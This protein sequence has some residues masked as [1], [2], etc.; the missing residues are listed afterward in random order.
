M[1]VS[2]S[3]GPANLALLTAA[4]VT[5]IF[6]ASASA[7]QTQLLQNRIPVTEFDARA[8]VS[9]TQS[10]VH[11]MPANLPGARQMV[12]MLNEQNA[13][14]ALSPRGSSNATIPSPTP[15][16]FYGGDLVFHGGPKLTSVKSH[17]I[18]VDCTPV[19]TCWGNPE[20]FLSDLGK[21][22]FIHLVDQ[23]TGSTANG[24][25]TVG[26]HANVS[27]GFFG[28]ALYPHD[29]FS[30]VHAVAKVTGT[31]YGHIYHI[32]LP[33]GVDTCFDLS[34]VCYSPDNPSSFFFCAYHGSVTFS[35]IGHVVYT[36]E[37]F[38]NVG[39]CRV[40]TPAPN[41]QLADSTNS[42]LSH[43][44]FEAI[45]DPDLNAWFN[46]T[47]LDLAGFEIGDECQPLGN[48]TGALDPTF[49]IN[50]KKYEV[51]TEY[52]NHYHAC[53]VVP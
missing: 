49:L 48:S 34:N 42:V 43:E 37:P 39:G 22:S 12:Q 23:Y 53:A 29:L 46:Q 7:Q 2:L 47:S 52:S 18:Y 10:R 6:C 38:Q 19:S 14:Q 31:G 51:Q 27:Y 20:G 9:T 44:L 4:L 8:A 26:T 32:F 40:S 28:N 13:P 15:P 5:P 24:R 3:L 11:V 1:K 25:Y 21:S 35:D 16:A 45:T 50:G 41:G 17:A 36:V 30:I 33:K